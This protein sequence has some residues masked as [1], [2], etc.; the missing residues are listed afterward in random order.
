M[1]DP[2]TFFD[3][4]RRTNHTCL[5]ANPHWRQGWNGFSSRMADA[6]GKVAKDAKVVSTYVLD[7]NISWEL[8]E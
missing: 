6:F 2:E 7:N 3:F 5:N 8:A 4:Y 1:K